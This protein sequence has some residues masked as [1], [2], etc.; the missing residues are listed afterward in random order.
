MTRRALHPL[1]ADYL[2][3][4]RQA[5]RDLP[6]ERLRDLL[7]EIE[8]YL[9]EAIPFGASDDAA[10]EALERLGPPGDV[11]EAE[12]SAAQAPD[13]RRG[14]REWAAVI[15]LPLGGFAFGVGWLVG[16]ILLWSSRL[17]TTGDKLIGTLVIPGGLATAL[18]FANLAVGSSGTAGCSGF[19]A[20]IN[21]STGAVI[22]R[23]TMHCTTPAGPST[24]TTVLHVA[25]AA[26]LVLGP[27]VSAV[28]LTR[29]ARNS[30]PSVATATL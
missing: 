28:Y 23:G 22:R 27:I 10:L 24:A 29:R 15:L 6:P 25:V 21:P 30:S 14:L 18:L 2:Q 4:L 26:V 17:W 11:I 1:A 20:Q 9:S 5:G 19:A 3:R 8:G 16:L 7:S 13:D 12:Q